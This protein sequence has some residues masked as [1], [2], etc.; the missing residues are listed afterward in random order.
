MLR[1]SAGAVAICACMA[2]VPAQTPNE[3]S[4]TVGP[5]INRAADQPGSWWLSD[6][7]EALHR[8]R[9]D[10]DCSA[11]FTDAATERALMPVYFYSRNGVCEESDAWARLQQTTRAE[12]YKGAKLVVMDTP[13]RKWLENVPGGVRWRDGVE[14]IR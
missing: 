5:A 7:P 6:S 10:T 12:E 2:C 9:L 8:A 1:W 3:R 14:H 13:L 11:T 4:D